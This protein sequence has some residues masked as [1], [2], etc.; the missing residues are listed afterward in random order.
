VASYRAAPWPLLV[1]EGPFEL[2]KRF[3]FTDEA[4]IAVQQPG[5]ERVDD[6]REIAYR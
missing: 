3:F 4:D 5:A 6:I 2:E 1:W